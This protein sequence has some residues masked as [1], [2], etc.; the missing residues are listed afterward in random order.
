MTYATRE[1][2][3]RI[4]KENRKA[5]RKRWRQSVKGKAWDHAYYQRPSVK[6]KAR[7][8][9][10]ENKHKNYC[11]QEYNDN[12]NIQNSNRFIHYDT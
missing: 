6:L 1:I 12:L 10:Y 4:N 5:A 8:K 11:K 7:K 2:A 9:Y 3:D